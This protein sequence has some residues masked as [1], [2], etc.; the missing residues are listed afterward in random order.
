M[1]YTILYVDDIILIT[2]SNARHSTSGYCVYLEN[3]LI[4]WS[5][6]CQHTLSRFSVKAEYRGVSNV[7]FESCWIRNILLKLCH[8]V[9]KATLV[10]C[11]RYLFCL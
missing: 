8:S 4:S 6:K 7:V 2:L 9:T 1:A 5:V 10:Y 3:N 11:A